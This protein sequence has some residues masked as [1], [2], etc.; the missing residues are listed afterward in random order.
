MWGAAED[1]TRDLFRLNKGQS[2]SAGRV[3]AE[4]NADAGNYC[5][6]AERKKKTSEELK[7]E[8]WRSG[9]FEQTPNRDVENWLLNGLVSAVLS[10][11][12]RFRGWQRQ[13]VYVKLC[14]VTFFQVLDC[15]HRV[16]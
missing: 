9:A 11:R 16:V 2:R 1:P 10:H 8:G 12:G 3:R 7:R 5:V 15:I 13:G 14:S 4:L 6:D